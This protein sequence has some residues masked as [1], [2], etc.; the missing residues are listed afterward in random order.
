MVN[1]EFAT[2][3]R[4]VFGVGAVRQVGEMAAALGRCALVVNGCTSERATPLLQSLA[5]AGLSYEIFTVCD[6]PTVDVIVAGVLRARA[7]NCDIVIGFGGGS[8]LDTAKAVAA[9]VNNPGELLDYLEVIGKGK[10][11]LY[12]SAPCIAV[13]TT[14]GTG[15]EVTRNAVIASPAHR[16]KVSLRSPYLLPKVAVVDPEMTL[17]APP[18]VTA[19]TGMDALT[20]LIE[21]FVCNRA[22]PLTDAFCREGVPRAARSLRRA[23]E[24]GSDLAAREDMALASLLGGLAL[25]NAG[26]GAVHGFSGPVGGL[27]HAPHGA[28]CAALLPPVVALNVRALRE[29]QPDSPALKRYDEIAAM[30]TG[31]PRATADDA[32]QWVQE[33][34]QALDI[35][36]LSAYGM[37]PIHVDEVADRAAVATSM[38]A[39]PIPL[40]RAEMREILMRAL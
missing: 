15:A 10:T 1:F 23:F 4:I 2:A 17:S 9:I 22:N 8:A 30:L 31:D 36:P 34:A 35:P 12:P 14:A 38:K 40:T 21:P 32:V 37:E 27:F 24:Q 39:N 26:L 6:E 7:E 16:V 13:P 20:Q 5:E 19:S 33:L 28:V 29:R 11:I 3:A 25:A 18:A